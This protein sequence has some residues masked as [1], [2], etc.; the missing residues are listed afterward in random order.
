MSRIGDK[1]LHVGSKEI[2]FGSSTGRPP[3]L[4]G[5]P[6]I[7]VYWGVSVDDPDRPLDFWS[8]PTPV[9]FPSGIRYEAVGAIMNVEVGADDI[10]GTSGAI[11]TITVSIAEPEIRRILTDLGDPGPRMTLIRA[12]YSLDGGNSYAFMP[13]P[14]V[15][16]LSS[17]R[18]RDKIYSIDVVKASIDEQRGNVVY[19]SD[20]SHTILHPNDT[21]FSRLKNFNER[22]YVMP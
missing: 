11:A 8:G 15:G 21:G 4:S 2:V 14:I 5:A 16:R 10:R 17:P 7:T 13:S 18:T 9:S 20:E 19:M 3:L 6:G 12:I 22:E 1:F